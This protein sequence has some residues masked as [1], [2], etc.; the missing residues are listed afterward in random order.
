MT[1]PNQEFL[2]FVEDLLTNYLTGGD[3]SIQWDP[4][5]QKFKIVLGA[6]SIQTVEVSFVSSTS[7][8]GGDFPSAVNIAVRIETSDGLPLE[9]E[10]TVQVY[11][12]L[13]GSANN[14]TDY[15]MTTPQ[16]LTFIVGSSNLATQNAVVNISGANSPGDPTVIL[17]LQN[18]TGA[19]IVGGNHTLSIYN[20]G[21]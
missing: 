1:Q 9:S 2:D 5:L 16:T 10:V 18:P 6:P 4:D 3:W 17:G 13:T 11:D 20:V 15:T 14:P 12:T 21:V 8:A 19:L 7:G